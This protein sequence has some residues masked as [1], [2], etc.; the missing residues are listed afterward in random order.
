MKW[1][2][3]LAQQKIVPG[4]TYATMFWDNLIM[5]PPFA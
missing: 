4:N 5:A 1:H 2:Y 3:H